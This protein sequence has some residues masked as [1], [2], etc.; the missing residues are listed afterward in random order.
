MAAKVTKA[1]RVAFV[2]GVCA[3]PFAFLAG[4]D[5]AYFHGPAG[6]L[7]PQGFAAMFGLLAATAPVGVLTAIILGWGT[8]K[9]GIPGVGIVVVGMA[10]VLNGLF[11]GGIAEGVAITRT[12]ARG[13]FWALIGGV[14]LWWIV[15][16][17]LA[18]FW[19]TSIH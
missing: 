18:L 11:W 19:A 17:F 6:G 9:A 8:T 10:C 14:S 5:F 7:S 2:L 12:R 16:G 1:A 13:M 3:A 15:V 4:A